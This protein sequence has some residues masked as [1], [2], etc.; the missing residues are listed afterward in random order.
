MN[1]ATFTCPVCKAANLER[2]AL[3]EHVVS[4]H[5]HQRGVCPICVAQPWGDPNYVTSTSFEIFLRLP[6]QKFSSIESFEIET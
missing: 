2:A 6:D 5:P 1:R 3:V 4:K